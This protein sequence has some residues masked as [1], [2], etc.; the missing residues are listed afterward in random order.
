[1]RRAAALLAILPAIAAAQ[2]ASC[3]LTLPEGSVAVVREPNGWLGSS[4]SSARLDG[5]GMLSGHP[6]E[7][8]YLVPDGSRKVKGGST[9]W[10]FQSGQEKWLYCV[11]G[12]SA[13]QIAKRMDDKATRCLVTRKEER[14]GV[15]VEMTAVC[16]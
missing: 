10:T 14:Q 1:M 11:Y 12:T 7:M 5:G 15:V 3:P 9:T 4:P 2:T 6:K 13:I 8:Q 16:K